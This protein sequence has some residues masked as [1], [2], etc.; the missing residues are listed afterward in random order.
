LSRGA[1]LMVVEGA[2]RA[3]EVNLRAADIANM[4]FA[5]AADVDVV[6]VADIDRGGVIAAIVGTWEL[7]PPAERA[8]LKGYIINKF[9]GDATLFTPAVE[10]IK[11]RTGLDCLGI[12]PFFAE[13]GLLPAE[14][15]ATVPQG[16]GGGAIRIA[17]PR[18][19]RMANFDDFDPLAAE[20][21]VTL[22]FVAPGQALPGD[23]DWIILPGSKATI[24][25][26]AF[27]RAQGWDIDLAAHLRRGGRVL[28]ICAGFQM[29]G[30]TVADPLGLEGP[31]GSVAKGLGY[32]DIETIMGA[33]KTLAE[34]VGFD[35]AGH[36][37]HGYEMHM[38]RTDG[39]DC[40]RPFLVLANRPDGAMSADG[41]VMGGYLHGLFSSD[42]FRAGFLGHDSGLAHDLLVDRVLDNLAA[43]LGRHVDLDR[44]L[45]L[46][47][48][49]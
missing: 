20:P 8:R 34:M 24:A 43:H 17:V 48:R 37:V 38:G 13:A 30:K 5:E 25:D 22:T 21:G 44:L 23:A 14:D 16:G 45:Q 26:L 2:G 40:A 10:L 35:H 15:G 1:D 33:D 41:R 11:A 19:S 7:L 28:G 18:L 3:A 47:T 32:L 6:L 49:S 42:R 46:A 9:R 36:P 12:V 39:P 4:G 29:L 31:A 27:L